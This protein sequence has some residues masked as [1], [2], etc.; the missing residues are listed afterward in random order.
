[1]DDENSDATG[2]AARNDTTTLRTVAEVE[3][4]VKE[5]R[6]RFHAD[7]GRQ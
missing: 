6:K 7:E 2:N 3:N 1:M 5:R 4:W